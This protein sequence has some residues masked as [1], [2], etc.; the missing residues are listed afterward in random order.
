[1]KDAQCWWVEN[2]ASR[3]V[4]RCPS[5]RQNDLG[6]FC[7]YHFK[8]WVDLVKT[9]PQRDADRR[10]RMGLF[11]GKG[12]SG[13]VGPGAPV[14]Q[15]GGAPTQAARKGKD[16]QLSAEELEKRHE[17]MARRAFGSKA[18]KEAEEGF[19]KN[20]QDLPG[21]YMSIIEK[22]ILKES[23]D[24]NNLG[25][26]IVVV[27]KKPIL[28]MQPAPNGG[29]TNVV[30][31]TTGQ[32]FKLSKARAMGSFRTFVSKVLD[33]PFDDPDLQNGMAPTHVSH[34]IKQPLAG[35]IVIHRNYYGDKPMKTKDKKGNDQW[36][37]NV[38][39]E[40]QVSATELLAE[41]ANPENTNLAGLKDRFFPNGI[42]EARAE[43]EQAAG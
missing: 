38:D 14:Q 41:F 1:M 4:A 9:Q 13:P 27:E 31:K 23:E 3:R 11:G 8:V 24:P 42:L 30:G 40:R 19:S 5:Q 33:I 22:V 17:E 34:P 18:F 39:Y 26:L 32:V 6:G 21:Y 36:W 10:E 25:A 29:P 2:V 16:E 15:Q 7:G 28:V 35:A 43:A 12:P 20:P 37:L